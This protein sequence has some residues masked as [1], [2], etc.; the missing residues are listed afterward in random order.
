M[1][2]FRLNARNMGLGS[3]TLRERVTVQ[4][5]KNVRKGQ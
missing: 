5:R 2:T 1:T 3:A 4:L